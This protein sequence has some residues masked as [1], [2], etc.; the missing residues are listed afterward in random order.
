MNPLISSLF[1]LPRVRYAQRIFFEPLNG[2]L[3]SRASEPNINWV[4]TLL[5]ESNNNDIQLVLEAGLP[6]PN[7]PPLLPRKGSCGSAV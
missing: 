1:E 5:E 3:S 2:A 6:E 7:W 4:T